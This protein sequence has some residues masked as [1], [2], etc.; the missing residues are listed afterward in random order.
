ME[1][2]ECI[3][4]SNNKSGIYFIFNIVTRNLYVGSTVNFKKRMNR[5]ILELRNSKHCNTHLQNAWNKYGM[6]SFI[7]IVVEYTS[8]ENLIEREQ[9]WLE[10][11]DFEKQLYNICPTADSRLGRLQTQET[12]NK[13]SEAAKT[14]LQ[15]EDA[16]KRI[17]EAHKGKKNSED[18][19]RKLSEANKGR[20]VSIETRR[21][22]SEAN[23][24]KSKPMS[25]ETRKCLSK[26]RIG[27]RQSEETKR[28][29]SDKN[30]GSK[31][32]EESKKRMSDAQKKRRLK[33]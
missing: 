6:E 19:R 14:R 5:H 2:Y 24:G 31:R 20:I 3:D 9:F 21:K 27:R 4:E 23:K 8:I 16:R 12:K 25:E 10:Q 30:K 29:I 18:C 15:N 11:F 13:I 22:I 7:F 32:S 17:S 33:V 1:L 28:K 26:L